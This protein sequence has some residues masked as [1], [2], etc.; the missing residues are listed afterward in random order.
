MITNVKIFGFEDYIDIAEKNWPMFNIKWDLDY[1]KSILANEIPESMFTDGSL[2]FHFPK[3][4]IIG[5]VNFN[6]FFDKIT[7]L[8][9]RRSNKW[10]NDLNSHKIAK[11]IGQC[12]S[13]LTIH[14]PHV[15][16][17]DD[18]FNII[19]GHHR[20]YVCLT[21][22]ISKI[23]ILISYSKKKYFEQKLQNIEWIERYNF[24]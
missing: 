21:K 9:K 7:P 24:K 12:V 10:K 11:I 16:V 6:D 14:P 1:K 5:W 15:D 23:P 13:G 8:I 20:L 3:G 19:N 22:K 4:F 2:S 18:G 17:D